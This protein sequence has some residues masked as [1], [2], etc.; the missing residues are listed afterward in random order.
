LDHGQFQANI[1]AAKAYLV[2]IA[3]QNCGHRQH[4]PIAQTNLGFEIARHNI[5]NFADCVGHLG[6]GFFR[7]NA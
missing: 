2:V 7:G 6:G 4:A 3:D 1:L 5:A